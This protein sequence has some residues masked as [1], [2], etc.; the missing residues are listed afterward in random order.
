MAP[1]CIMYICTSWPQCLKPVISYTTCP[2]QVRIQREHSIIP[3]SVY[4]KVKGHTCGFR[5]QESSAYRYDLCQLVY[6]RKAN[7]LAPHPCTTG[8][9]CSFSPHNAQH[10]TSGKE[11]CDAS[12]YKHRMYIPVSGIEVSLVDVGTASSVELSM[13][14]EEKIMH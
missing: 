8:E 6:T 3:C 10:W 2:G 11:R 14:T 9:V 7:C 12:V 1:F 4:G 13:L 5:T